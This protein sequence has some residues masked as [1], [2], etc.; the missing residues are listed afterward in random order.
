MQSPPILL[1][2]TLVVGLCL[3]GC[4]QTTTTDGNAVQ[5]G[6]IKN[7]V[8]F[9]DSY[10]DPAAEFGGHSWAA[11]VAEYGSFNLYSFAKSGATCSNN[12]TYHPFP[13]ITE[14]Q[15]PTYINAKQNGTIP[16]SAI[17]PN[18]TVYAIWI[19]T[20][21][22]GVNALLTDGI[23]VR[24]GV[25]IVEVRKCV[26]N[27][28]ET[29]YESG[30]RNFVIL[31][32]IPLNLTPLY[33]RTSYPNP[34]W[35]AVRNTTE[36]NIFMYEL[37]RAGNAITDLMFQTVAPRLQGAHIASFDAYAL[38]S[39][40]FVNPGAYLNGTAANPAGNGPPVY[41]V[42]G[43]VNSCVLQLNESL[44]G[45][46]TCTIVQDEVQQDAYLWYNELHPSQQAHR[47]L[48]AEFTTLMKGKYSRWT[49][50]LS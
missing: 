6:Q 3:A 46:A 47:V 13:P 11:Y 16:A 18:E 4:V 25:S 48:A 38:F 45:P 17:L 29:L 20:N 14:Y 9:G 24:S 49:T 31:N 34:N 15:L 19:G 44:S 21:D 28:V 1:I 5:P 10:T 22:V 33:S 50:W 32:M 37:V 12:L 26:V 8:T 42:T 23:G 43:C 2:L 30:A 7:L 27:V 40:M 39:D 41:N 36:W 35:S